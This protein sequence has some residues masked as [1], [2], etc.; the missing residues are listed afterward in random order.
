MKFAVRAKVHATFGCRRWSAAK[1]IELQFSREAL[2]LR[3]G[4]A[5]VTPAEIDY[6]LPNEVMNF[7]EPAFRLQPCVVVPEI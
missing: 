1:E 3:I 2:D 5:I 6:G 7:R 4:P